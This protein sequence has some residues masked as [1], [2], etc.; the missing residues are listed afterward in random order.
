MERM[1]RALQSSGT[2]T[3]VGSEG[4]G[5]VSGGGGDE[6]RG[7]GIIPTASAAPPLGSTIPTTPITTTALPPSHHPLQ[8]RIPLTHAP[9]P[10]PPPPPQLHLPLHHL[11]V[12]PLNPHSHHH[13]TLSTSSPTHKRWTPPERTLL[14][15]HLTKHYTLYK[16]CQKSAIRLIA[17]DAFSYTRSVESIKG[18]WESMKKKY[19]IARRI[20]IDGAKGGAGP[21]APV[22]G[23]D[24]VRWKKVLKVCPHFKEIDVIAKVERARRITAAVGGN[25]GVRSEREGGGGGGGGVGGNMERGEFEE[26]LEDEYAEGDIDEIRHD[27]VED[28]SIGITSGQDDGGLN[29]PTGEKRTRDETEDSASP[30]VSSSA[31]QTPAPLPL[32]PSEPDPSKRQKVTPQQHLQPSTGNVLQEISELSIPPPPLPPPI[33][34]L[35]KDMVVDVGSRNAF[36]ELRD[37]VQKNHMEVMAKYKEIEARLEEYRELSGIERRGG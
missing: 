22:G 18:Q 1:S 37:L 36:L 12:S 21:E 25:G 15:S 9:P 33:P 2:M 17:R 14:L 5:M 35:P 32:P 7:S 10:S 27:E 26:D 3:A 24:E 11:P 4:G 34:G 29:I 23:V 16:S 28:G 13:H 6:G 30:S 8:I 19:K 20:L 31:N